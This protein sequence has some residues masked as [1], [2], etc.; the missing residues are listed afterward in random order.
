MYK[1]ARLEIDSYFVWTL[2][3]TC[4]SQNQSFFR[5]CHEDHVIFFCHK[6]HIAP[7]PISAQSLLLYSTE[8]IFVANKEIIQLTK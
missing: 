3:K 2:V 8:N 1:N 4:Q 5:N 7:L 6:F